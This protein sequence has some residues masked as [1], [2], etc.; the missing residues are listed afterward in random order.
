M[1]GTPCV[2]ICRVAIAAR[3]EYLEQ[4]G[5]RGPRREQRDLAGDHDVG[6]LLR[7]V[8]GAVAVR[9]VAALLAAAPAGDWR[10][11]PEAGRPTPSSNH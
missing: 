6:A 5:Q 9:E 3:L 1:G 2:T 10:D 4:R 7:E 11:E 8:A